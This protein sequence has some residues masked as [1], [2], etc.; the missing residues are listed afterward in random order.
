MAAV[1]WMHSKGRPVIG[2]GL[3]APPL[4]GRLASMMAKRRKKILGSLDAIIAYSHM[5]AEEYILQGIPSKSVF[6]AHNAVA[7]SPGKPLIK[8]PIQLKGKGKVLFVGR[9]QRRKR[10]DILLRACAT[11]PENMQPDLWIIGDGPARPDY[12]NLASQ[13]YPQAKFLG[14]RYGSEISHFFEAADLFVLPG[15]GGLAVQEAMAYS[16]PVI[17]ARGDGTQEDLVR[18]CKGTGREN[19]WLVPPDDLMA[20]TE[21]LRTALSDIVRLRRMGA[22]SYRIVREE[23][24]IDRMVAVF[25]KA[26]NF[27]VAG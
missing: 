10:I 13:I 27:V 11:L 9:L 5:G 7:S 19:G 3:G 25:S 26:F 24:N 8:R 1:Q 16:L 21:A 6:V 23:I 14:A 18:P 15:S 12:E 2:W 22:E 20:L 4:R 17:V